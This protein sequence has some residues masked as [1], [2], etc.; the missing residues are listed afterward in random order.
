MSELPHTL[1]RLEL[2]RRLEHVFPYHSANAAYD[3]FLQKVHMHACFLVAYRKDVLG[4][5]AFYANDKVS[6]TAYLTHI[7][8]MQEAQGKHVGSGL[9]RQAEDISR[10]QGMRAMKLEVREDNQQ[11]QHFYRWHGYYETGEKTK[12]GFYMKKELS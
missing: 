10:L 6:K 9:L 8:V 4:I 12:T 1:Q 5:A 2:I 7:A 3:E 11:A